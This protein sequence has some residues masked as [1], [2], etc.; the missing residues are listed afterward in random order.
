MKYLTWLDSRLIPN[1]SV[2]RLTG[3]FP[4]KLITK[5]M[6]Q[7]KRI[8]YFTSIPF[9]PEISMAIKADGSLSSAKTTKRC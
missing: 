6:E 2:N 9:T 4:E 5:N 3:T 1:F 8:Q 7:Q